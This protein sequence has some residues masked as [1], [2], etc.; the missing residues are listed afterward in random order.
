M[1]LTVVIALAAAWMSSTGSPLGR[2]KRCWLALTFAWLPPPL[3]ALLSTFHGLLH[4]FLFVDENWSVF[5]A[6]VFGIGFSLSALRLGE[7]GLSRL[8]A[9]LALAINA[10]LVSWLFWCYI[11]ILR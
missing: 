4:A 2:S 6:W 1:I 11:D 3:F 5:I 9:C 7:R 10:A 8:L